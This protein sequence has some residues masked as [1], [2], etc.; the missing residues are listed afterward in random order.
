MRERGGKWCFGANPQ[1]LGDPFSQRF[2][3]PDL[4]QLG[5]DGYYEDDLQYIVVVNWGDNPWWNAEQ[6]QLRA[7]DY[8][9]LS[10]AKYDWIW[11]GKFHDEVEDSI[12]KPEWFDAA[13][14]AHKLDRLKAVFKPRG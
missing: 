13:V 4:A 6:E 10:R 12:I 5:R 8:E 9:N 7:W 1:S 11:E 14:D 2:I 3:V